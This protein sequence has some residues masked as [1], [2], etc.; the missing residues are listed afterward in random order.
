MRAV[1]RAVARTAVVIGRIRRHASRSRHLNL[2]RYS[3][4]GVGDYRDYSDQYY[5]G[6]R[7]SHSNSSSGGGGL[8]S[9]TRR[10]IDAMEM[11]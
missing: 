5:H 3:Q 8:S 7:R 2:A 6:Y 4:E 1:P 9:S 10:A 11:E